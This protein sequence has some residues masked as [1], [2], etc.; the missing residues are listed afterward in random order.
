MSKYVCNIREHAITH[1]IRYSIETSALVVGVNSGYCE[2]S[3][4]R[5]REL[6]KRK[7]PFE[8]RTT[9]MHEIDFFKPKLADMF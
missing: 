9:L 6:T 3:P 5:K 4:P 1:Q 8:I 2:T 7:R